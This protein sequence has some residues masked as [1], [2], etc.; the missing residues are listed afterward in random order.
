MRG[1]MLNAVPEI[2]DTA[3]HWLAVGWAASLVRRE[4]SVWVGKV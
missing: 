2:S 4:A 1:G 3:A